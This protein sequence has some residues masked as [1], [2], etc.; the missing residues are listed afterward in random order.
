M[1]E[2]QLRALGPA[3]ADYLERFLFCCDYTQTFRHLST[4]CHGLLSPLERKT[5]EPIAL[6]AGVPVRTLQ[7]F[8]TQHGWDQDQ[9][10]HLLQ[11]HTAALLGSLPD[12]G[13][14]T[15]GLIDESGH[16]KKGT[17]TPGVQRQYCGTT[18]KTDNC[19]VTVHLGL[20]DADF[21]ALLDGE[22]YLP[23]SWAQDPAR[24][25]AARIPED[26]T[27]RPKDRKSVV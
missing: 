16:V 18:G 8:L 25:K 11:R 9:A 7:L 22:L 5:C 13:T 19:S 6:A 27:F 12:D 21:H 17:K 20:A 2:Q 26:M 23:E 15:V 3:L 14:G 1:T 4:Y 24:C 10:R